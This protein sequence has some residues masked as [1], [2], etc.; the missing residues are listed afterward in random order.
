MSLTAIIHHQIT[1]INVWDSSLLNIILCA[2]NSLYTC[3]SNSINKT[4]LLLTDVPE[5]V[6][7]SDRMYFLQYSDPFAGDLFMTT[8][9]LP[10]YSLKN[11]LNNLFL[12]SHLNY[13]HC[14]L[15]IDCN[16][17]AIFKTSEGNFKMFD[18]HSRDS[19]GI[20]HPFGK[21]VLISVESINNLV[22]YFQNTVPPG[23]VT[24]FEIKGVTVQLANSDITQKYIL[25]SSGQSA[26]ECVKQKRSMETEIEK[27]I[28]LEN[29]RKYKKTK[30]AAETQNEKQTR[31]E[32]DRKYKKT[33]QAVETGDEKQTRLENDRKY[34]KRKRAEE[35]AIEM[36][37]RLAN[38]KQNMKKKCSEK[39]EI[40]KSTRLEQCS[41][42]TN[43]NQQDYLKEFDI[44]QNGSIHE[45]SWAKYNINKF[46]KSVEFAISQCTICQEGWPLKSKH[47]SPENYVCSRCSRDT[48][49]PKKFSFEN[50]MIP[51]TVPHESQELTQ[52]E[53]ICTITK[54]PYVLYIFIPI[55][56]IFLYDK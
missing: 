31:L 29:A 12:D 55:S 24:P 4:F 49:S 53:E 51:S 43:T 1:N 42:N 5:M 56:F 3:I 39:S 34:Q 20:P 54:I 11:A 10:Y 38:A 17:V 30:Q 6:S 2:G 48:K 46:H 52:V 40:K 45:Q 50:S 16:T 26:K 14:L 19:Y 32:N 15:T 33:K 22:I 47:R 21:C 37:A 18:S 8:N 7:V 9:N 28:R 36:Q 27:Q 13:Q 25:T 23:N 35:T 41:T 44:I